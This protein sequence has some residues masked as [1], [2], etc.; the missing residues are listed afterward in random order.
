MPMIGGY[1]S[2]DRYARLTCMREWGQLN[3]AGDGRPGEHP[4]TWRKLRGC[5]QRAK[6]ALKHDAK[7]FGVFAHDRL[8]TASQRTISIAPSLSLGILERRLGE[9]ISPD[10]LTAVINGDYAGA[11]A[12]SRNGEQITCGAT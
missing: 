4:T 5:G 9:K 12:M 6:D 7:T 11:T 1:G 8:A 2:C 3:D 10:V